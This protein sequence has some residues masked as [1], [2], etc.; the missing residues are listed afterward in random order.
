MKVLNF[1][2]SLVMISLL[3]NSISFADEPNTS[4]QEGKDFLVICR[5]GGAGGY[6]AFPDVCRLPDGRLFCVFYDGY[7]HVALPN[8]NHPKGGRISGIFS[9]DEGKTWS[10]PFV[11][12]DSPYDDRDP[13]IAVIDGKKLICNFFSLKPVENQNKRYEGLGTWVIVSEDMGKKWSEPKQL[14]PDYYCSSPIRALP[15]GNLIIPLYT[16]KRK[17]GCGAVS[18]STDKGVSWCKPIDIDYGDLKL[19]AEPDICVLKNQNLFIAQRGHSDLTMGYSLSTDGGNT[20]SKSEALPFSGH[21]PYLH[22]TP[23]G[24]L[25]M[26]IRYPHKGTY[27][28]ISIDEAKTWSNPILV[29]SCIGAYPSMVTLK[30]NSILIV[31]YEE[32]EG[33]NLRA[34][35]FNVNPSG[36]VQWLSWK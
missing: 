17:N 2:T 30:D 6:E 27:I 36:E 3:I 8:E 7:A 15:N 9:S 13:S 20:W 28:T 1:S 10:V 4:L 12:Y 14:F 32:G 34:R 24:V 26:G 16:D 11:V 23:T 25:V 29:D 5:D 33:S 18:I 19:D 22:R 21:C 31:Y 35:K